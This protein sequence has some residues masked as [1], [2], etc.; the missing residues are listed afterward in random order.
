M[1]FAW[2]KKSLDIDLVGNISL[3]SAWS[4][5]SLGTF[6]KIWHIQIEIF[7]RIQIKIYPQ[8]S[9]QLKYGAFFLNNKNSVHTFCWKYIPRKCFVKKVLYLLFGKFGTYK[10][11]YSTV[12]CTIYTSHSIIYTVS[13]VP[14]HVHIVKCMPY[15]V[16]YSLE[17]DNSKLHTVL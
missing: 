4:K 2:T 7:W 13:C 1:H 14:Y 5:S 9:I 6:W 17:I 16:D 12:H 10:S 11:K 15:T 8:T 3:K